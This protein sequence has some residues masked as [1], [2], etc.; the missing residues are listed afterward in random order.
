MIKV[1]DE[2]TSLSNDHEIV[3]VTMDCLVKHVSLNRVKVLC[4]LFCQ[5]FI[6]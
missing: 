3:N 5:I 1:F 6:A 4:S 2:L